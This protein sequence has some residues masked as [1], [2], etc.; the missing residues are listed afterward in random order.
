MTA[1]HHIRDAQ[2]ELA[3]WHCEVFCSNCTAAAHFGALYGASGYLRQL[4]S[5]H[6]RCTSCVMPPPPWPGSTGSWVDLV[7]SQTASFQP[8]A[9]QTTQRVRVPKPAAKHNSA[10]SCSP[11][12]F[13]PGIRLQQQIQAAQEQE[14][15][16]QQCRVVSC[17][18]G[19]NREAEKDHLA[20]VVRLLACAALAWKCV[21]HHC[22][23]LAAVPVP[24]T[25]CP[26][27][28]FSS[29]PLLSLTYKVTS[30]CVLCCNCYC[31]RRDLQFALGRDGAAAL[32][33]ASLTRT[34]AAAAASKQQPAASVKEQLIDQVRD[35][36]IT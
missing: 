12:V 2:Q 1:C 29:A 8:P 25:G 33:A 36:I 22:Y 24:I 19:M 32:Q 9:S 17:K 28:G 23:E 7:S 14:Q 16:Q 15:Q 21:V 34:T 35:H 27:E 31:K 13:R 10:N 6:T 11:P 18:P 30:H 4:S 26:P 20:A 5:Q 3:K